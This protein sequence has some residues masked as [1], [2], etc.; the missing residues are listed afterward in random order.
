MSVAAGA[1][2]AKHAGT[3]AV[4]ICVRCG[5]FVC[6]ECEELSVTDEVFCATCF[7]LVKSHPP[8]LRSYLA[9][10][11]LVLACLLMLTPWFISPLGALLGMAFGVP[12]LALNALEKRR[13]IV[14]PKWVVALGVLLVLETLAIFAFYALL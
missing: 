12:S 10:I 14:V 5:S 9:R 1:M 2:C 6:A 4:D 7:E 11:G 13:R 3:P 8:T